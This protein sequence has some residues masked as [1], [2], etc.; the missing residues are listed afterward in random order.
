MSVKLSEAIEGVAAGVPFVA[1]P[2][3]EKGRPAPL[4]LT[5]HLLGAP[6]ERAA[7]TVRLLGQ[8]ERFGRATEMAVL[9]RR[10]ERPHL[11]GVEVHAVSCSRCAR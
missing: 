9:R 4:V 5:W 7:G 2:P 6:T 10:D 1:L 3:A 8:E 11:R